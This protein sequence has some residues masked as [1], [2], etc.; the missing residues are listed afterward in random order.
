[1][2]ITEPLQETG[3]HC[4]LCGEPLASNA[5]Q[6]T[7]CDWV[8]G[9]FQHEEEH[10]QRNPR[11]IAAV[12]FSVIPGAGH[13]FKGYVLAAWLLL[14]LGVPVILTMAFTFTMFFGW[15]MVPVYWVA[16]AMDA[17]FRKDLRLKPAAVAPR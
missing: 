11:D 3:F 16:V 1:M 7:K 14:V 4:P 10:R 9:Y 5:T 6:C 13:Y 2:N 15:L 8:P 17:Y 12:A